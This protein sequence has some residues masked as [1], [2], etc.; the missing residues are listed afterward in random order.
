MSISRISGSTTHGRSVTQVSGSAANSSTVSSYL[1]DVSSALSAGNLN[2]AKAAFAKRSP[3]RAGNGGVGVAHPL[4]HH[5][6]GVPNAVLLNVLN[7]STTSR[8][9]AGSTRHSVRV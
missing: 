2:S 9:S 3:H 8:S 7:S 6:H 5:G 1:Q 4:G